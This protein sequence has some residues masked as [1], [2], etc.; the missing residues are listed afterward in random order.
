AIK[1]V[2]AEKEANDTLIFDEID[3]GVSG[4]AALKI[5]KL[6]KATAKNRQVICVTHSPQIAAFSDNHMFI[7]K[8]TME[9]SVVTTVRELNGQERVAEIARIIS[10]E[11]ITAAAMAN[12]QEMITCAQNC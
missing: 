9:K 6:L 8:K 10:G 3:S 2:L 11:S 4:S 1:S 12:A 5:G 7:E